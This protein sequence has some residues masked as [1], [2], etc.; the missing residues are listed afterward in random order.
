MVAKGLNYSDARQRLINAVIDAGNELIK[1]AQEYIGDT[2]MLTSVDITIKLDP[3]QVPIIEVKQNY[4]CKT[5]CDRM[6][7]E[8]TGDRHHD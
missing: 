2:E 3:T 8:I 7:H 5:A 4:I 6:I 1:N